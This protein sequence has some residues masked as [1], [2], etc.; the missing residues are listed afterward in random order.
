L[1]FRRVLTTLR[2]TEDF[3]RQI[4][5]HPEVNTDELLPAE[6]Y[7]QHNGARLKELRNEFGGHI[8]PAGVKFATGHVS[9]VTGKITMNRHCDGW[10]LGLDC[11]FASHLVSAVIT[12]K[13]Q[14]IDYL[15]ELRDA[16]KVIADGFNQ[17]QAAT[18]AL[19]Y[20]FLWSRFGK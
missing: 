5:F 8:Q 12:S 13:L 6:Q 3:K 19:V 2:R 20:L 10:T 15:Q 9:D 4:I 1:E 17:V 14:G 18:A 7:F 16:F 11:D